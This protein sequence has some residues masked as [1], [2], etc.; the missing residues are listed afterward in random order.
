MTMNQLL[1]FSDRFSDKDFDKAMKRANM[2]IHLRDLLKLK[3]LERR[4]ESN[5]GA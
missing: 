3:R 1:E 4:I 5:R 2:P